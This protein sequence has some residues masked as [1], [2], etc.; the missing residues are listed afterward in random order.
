MERL[1]EMRNISRSQAVREIIKVADPEHVASVISSQE[2]RERRREKTSRNLEPVRASLNGPDVVGV[3][4]PASYTVTVE[5]RRKIRVSNGRRRQDAENGDMSRRRVAVKLLVNNQKVDVAE[6][7]VPFEDTRTFKLQ[8]TPSEPWHSSNRDWEGEPVNK[9][10][11]AS[12]AGANS[13]MTLAHTDKKLSARILP[14]EEYDARKRQQARKQ[15]EQ[16]Q[17]QPRNLLSRLLG[18]GR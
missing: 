2:K 10:V 8:W 1:A 4:R 14:G 9:Q 13:S 11:S 16:E 12:V 15:Q 18:G 6:G 5:N 17:Q 7:V 3:G